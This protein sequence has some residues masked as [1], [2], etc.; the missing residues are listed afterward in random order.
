MEEDIRKKEGLTFFQRLKVAIF[1]LEDY[2][3]FLDESPSKAFKYFFLLAL[4]V[5]VLIAAAVTFDFSKGVLKVFHYV[6]EEIPSFTLQNGILNFEEYV[7]GYDNDFDFRLI[8]NTFDVT[9]EEIQK[10]SNKIKDTSSRKW[11]INVKR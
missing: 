4:C 10:Y 9:D 6:K 11:N 5:V 7:E 2:G 3:N 8:I 1:K